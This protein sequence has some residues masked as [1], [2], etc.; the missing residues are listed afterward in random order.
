MSFWNYFSNKQVSAPA[1][2]DTSNKSVGQM[3][4]TPY[5][6]VGGN[7]LS[8]PYINEMYRVNNMV[9]FG[10]DNLY[11]QFLNQ[12]AISSPLHGAII[13][14]VTSAA[15]GAG[16]EWQDKGTAEMKVNISMFENKYK[17]KRLVRTLTK[18]FYIHGR[19]TCLVV[20]T[21]VKDAQGKIVPK[22][23]F[24]RIDP[25]CIRNNRTNTEFEYSRDWSTQIEREFLP[26]YTDACNK[27]GRYL[28]NYQ[29]DTPGQ[30]VYP[31]AEY[32]AA[33][34]WIF[35]DGEQSYLHKA[36][37]QN[38]IFPSLV[39]SRPKEFTSIEEVQKYKAGI[40]NQKQTGNTGNILVFTANSK[41]ELPTITE[42]NANKNDNLFLQTSKEIKDNICFAHNIN[43][44]I[45][46]IKYAGSMGNNQELQT[47]YGIFEKN[48][49]L[50]LR[51]EMEY[52][53]NDLIQLTGMHNTI[54][55]N[56]FQ[57]IDQ[58]IVDTTLSEAEQK[59]SATKPGQKTEVVKDEYEV[60]DS[61][62]GLSAAD[63]ADIL[64]VVRDHSRGKMNDAMAILRLKSYGIT[65]E[66]AKA[67]LGLSI[68]G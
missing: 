3:L 6:E 1:Q 43:P 26:V 56:N 19:V 28:Y 35:L 47:S 5:R 21:M 54:V 55:I 27:E 7:N 48:V 63:N 10:D 42:V 13:K 23:T 12:M 40:Q 22:K 8:L 64:R 2:S 33:N 32:N 16:Y 60:N 29:I 46:G 18:D 15:V 59:N 52:I 50:P 17:F 4:S 37:L 62:K 25:A 49:V 58:V 30:D 36:N 24:K 39:L 51:E 9:R 65:E 20:V 57:L 68:N 31:L 14:F 61:L 66:D 41:D 45:I 38:S 67:I 11:P 34:N 44:S 53:L